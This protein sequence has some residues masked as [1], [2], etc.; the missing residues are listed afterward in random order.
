MDEVIMKVSMQEMT[1][2]FGASAKKY[3]KEVRAPL[4]DEIP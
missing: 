1:E 3:I 4:P 2:K